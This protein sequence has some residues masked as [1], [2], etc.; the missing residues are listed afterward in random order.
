MAM[1]KKLMKS[2]LRIVILVLVLA[3]MIGTGCINSIMFHPEMCRGGY[4]ETTS[5][6]VDIGTDGTKIAAVTIGPKKG[7][8]AILYCHGNA[9]LLISSECFC[10]NL[11]RNFHYGN[12][13]YGL[14][15]L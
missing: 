2:L 10:Y 4:R 6:Y 12:G 13:R 9:R 3:L 11:N 5:G 7:K 14:R 8:K 1:I 15:D